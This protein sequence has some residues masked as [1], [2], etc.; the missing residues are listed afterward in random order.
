MEGTSEA[1]VCEFYDEFIVVRRVNKEI[2]QFDITMDNIVPVTVFDG[3]EHLSKE[4]LDLR[5]IKWLIPCC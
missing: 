3:R 5:L 2:L 4:Q 1:K